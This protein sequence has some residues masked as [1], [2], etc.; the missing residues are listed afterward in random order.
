MRLLSKTE[1]KAVVI[2]IPVP[3][4]SISHSELVQEQKSDPSVKALFERVSPAGDMEIAAQEYFVQSVV[5][6]R[7][8]HAQ[9]NMSVG[10]PVV[11]IVVP[12][13]FSDTFLASI[14]KGC[15]CFH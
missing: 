11:Q 7:K 13:K 1:I 2:F 4:E 14:E 12:A 15:V 5:L 3:L 9:V 8:W 10:K 6:V